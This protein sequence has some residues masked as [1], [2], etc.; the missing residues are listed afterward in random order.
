[1]ADRPTA[2]PAEA[3]I[4]CGVLGTRIRSVAADRPKALIEICGKPFLEWLIRGLARDRVRRVVLAVGYMG[5]N[6]RSVIGIERCGIEIAY[7]AEQEPLGTGGALRLAL[8]KTSSATLLVMN[9]DSMCSYDAGR[10]VDAH[11]K[12][13]AKAT[14]WLAPASDEERFG[15]VAIDADGKVM[16]FSEKDTRHNGGWINAGVYVID[17]DAIA[18]IQPHEV[19]SLEREVFPGLVGRGLYGVAGDGMFFDIGTPEALDEA[20]VRLAPYLESLKCP[21]TTE[22]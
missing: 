17:R 20:Q 6:I 13:R 18:S 4:L 14:L 22:D 10:L 9:G 3:V 2:G 8:D 16:A 12:N 19:V 15:K 5:E 21:A 1:V 11:V 7:S